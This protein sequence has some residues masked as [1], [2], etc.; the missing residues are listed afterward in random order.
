MV[1]NYI[2]K[3]DRQAWSTESMANAVEA[4]VSGNMG[5]RRAASAFGVPQT[6]LERRVVKYRGNPDRILA[7]SKGRTNFLL[8]LCHLSVNPHEAGICKHTLIF[9]GM[10]N[11]KAVFSAEQEKEL[12][13]Y[14]KEMEV[15]LFGLSPTEIRHLAFQLAEK[16][17]LDHPFNH[18]SGVAGEDWWHCFQKRHPDLSIRKPE[19]TSAAR[20]MGFNKVAVSSF[21]GLL[22]VVVDEHKLTA[23]RIFN[24]DETGISCVPK[25]QSKIVAAKGR[26]QVGVLASAERGQNITAEICVCADGSY[27]PPMLIF[28]RMKMKPELLDGAPPGAIAACHPSGWMQ[29]DIFFN[30]FKNFVVFSRATKKSPS[31][32]F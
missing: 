16:N 29:T 9:T 5:Y 7:T 26:K 25:T 15:R 28:P 31:C 17:N 1:R 24:V 8:R 20:A 6:T 21:F 18:E 13:A 3:T 30:W 11:W 27:M 14:I 32:W 23:N 10:G 12:V 2:R 4:V 19:S 22:S